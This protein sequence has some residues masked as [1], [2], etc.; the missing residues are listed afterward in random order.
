MGLSFEYPGMIFFVLT[1]CT[2]DIL[3]LLGRLPSGAANRFPCVVFI[4]RRTDNK[5]KTERLNAI[6]NRLRLRAPVRVR[7]PETE[8]KIFW[9]LSRSSVT[10]ASG[11]TALE[12]IRPR[13]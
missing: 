5:Y 7:I 3:Y 8:G 9:L 10:P 13:F 11:R 1:L 12:I 2:S 4:Y 6:V